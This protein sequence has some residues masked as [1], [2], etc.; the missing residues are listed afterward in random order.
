ML[1]FA[2]FLEAFNQSSDISVKRS[3]YLLPLSLHTTSKE[4]FSYALFLIPSCFPAFF[5]VL[6]RVTA[7]K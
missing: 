4:V 3:F 6:Y 2:F 7:L 5:T 1:V